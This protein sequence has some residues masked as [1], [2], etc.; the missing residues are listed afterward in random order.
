MIA[1]AGQREEGEGR[2]RVNDKHVAVAC[3]CQS[4][5]GLCLALNLWCLG[6]RGSTGDF[7]KTAAEIT[8]WMTGLGPPARGFEPS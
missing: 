8:S 6:L 7:H 4:P 3:Y 1:A 2:L 5:E